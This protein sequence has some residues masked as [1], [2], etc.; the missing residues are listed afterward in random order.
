MPGEPSDRGDTNHV[1]TVGDS[2]HDLS[3]DFCGQC[4]IAT[5]C[6]PTAPGSTQRTVMGE[7][8]PRLQTLPTGQTL[9]RIGD[10]FT[11]LFGIRSGCFKTSVVDANG[12][13]HIINFHLPGELIGFDA[14]YPATHRSDAI[15][16]CDSSVCSLPFREIMDLAST[17]P[18]LQWRLFKII[19][20]EAFY[21]TTLTGDCSA[22]ERLAAFLL[23]LAARFEAIE[24]P[25][26][27]FA[28]PM[29]REDIAKHLGLAP[30]TISR[31]LRNFQDDGL[32]SVDQRRIK[33]LDRN[34]LRA[35]SGPM[36]RWPDRMQAPAP[37]DPDQGAT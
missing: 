28:L 27:D 33:I 32:L 25:A 37:P 12:R 17:L 8:K 26:T 15:A 4:P 18:S 36:N 23:S 14:I 24:L 7:V 10:E 34:R 31:L 16:V 9:F 6:V 1:C 13:E 20:R 22:A 11:A 21:T 29:S 2:A 5:F 3:G 35:Q 19:S 30:E